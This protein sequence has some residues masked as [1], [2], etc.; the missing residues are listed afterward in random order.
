TI[1]AIKGQGSKSN[2][3]LLAIEEDDSFY[4]NNATGNFFDFFNQRDT[5]T[6]TRLAALQPIIVIHGDVHDGNFFGR[7][8]QEDYHPNGR[9]GVPLAVEGEQGLSFVVA[10]TNRKAL[11]C[12]FNPRMAKTGEGMDDSFA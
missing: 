10:N 2:H 5:Q 3:D 12:L 11:R 9:F 4:A 8:P 6:D 7:S 1:H